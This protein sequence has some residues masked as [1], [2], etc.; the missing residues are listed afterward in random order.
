MSTPASAPSERR[1]GAFARTF[2]ALLVVAS[3]A[4]CTGVLS[5]DDYTSASDALCGLLDGC[6]S[7]AAITGCRKHVDDRLGGANDSLTDDWLASLASEGCL[8]NCAAARSC[9]DIEPVCQS[10]V[11][12]AC[13]AK[14]ECCSFTL[15][16]VD[17]VRQRCCSTDGQRCSSGADCCGT[18]CVEGFCGGVLCRDPGAACDLDE[19]CC[20][21]SCRDNACSAKICSP[22]GFECGGDAECCSR[23]CNAA[24]RC[25]QPACGREGSPCASAG[26]CCDALV[27]HD[28]GTKS[29][30]SPGAC[31]PREIDC[32]SD[33]Q[34]CTGFCD[35]VYR[36]CADGCRAAGNDCVIDGQCCTGKCVGGLCSGGCS[37]VYCAANEDC[38]SSRCVAHTCAPACVTADCSHDPCTVGGPLQVDCVGIAI[39]V[40]D[41]CKVDPYCCCNAW[42]S[43]C[44]SLAAAVCKPTVP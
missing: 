40:T 16:A 41:V 21:R 17:C 10:A 35:P 39:P 18:S 20:S 36:V 12:S 25:G 31:T 1:P 42:D 28:L 19:Q 22:D 2:A 4:S 38:C 5:L 30:C 11:S 13:V 7:G 23:S 29:F 32:G 26:D 9:L 34:C 3:V 27:C 33:S 24:G 6:Y 43:F 15:G 14:E 37:D 44:V 8:D